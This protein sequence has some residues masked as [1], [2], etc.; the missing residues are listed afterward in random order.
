MSGVDVD[1]LQQALTNS[2]LSNGNVDGSATA[3]ITVTV[4]LP[5]SLPA[6]S[7]GM[8]KDAVNSAGV[9]T[10]EESSSL[11]PSRPTKQTISTM[12]VRDV[13]TG[14]IRRHAVRKVFSLFAV[15]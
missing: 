2:G 14:K 9:S 8:P 7:G 12:A 5:E 1:L 6:A 10:L 4:P 11:V 3:S 13:F 15:L